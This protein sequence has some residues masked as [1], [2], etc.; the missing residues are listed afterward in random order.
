MPLDPQARALLDVIAS[1][2][3]P[4]L[5]QLPVDQARQA[6]RVAAALQ[7]P[8]E[9]VA[10]V[11]DR[12]LP[13]PVSPIPVRIY[14]PEASAPL[15]LLV[16]FHGGGHTVGDLDSQDATCRAIANRARLLI[17]SVDYRLAPE[18]P[19]P[20]PL[21]DCYAATAWLAE[22]GRSLGADPRRLAVGGD[23]AGGNLAAAVCL[24]ARDLAGP[25]IAF[26]LLI[27]PAVDALC[28]SASHERNAEGYLLTRELI[29]WF[30]GHHVPNEKDKLNPY[31]SPLRAS[32]LAGLPPALVI[33]AEFDPLVDEG[34]AYA[35]RLR[36]AGVKV[37]CQR[38]D[39]MIHGFFG[40]GGFLD[41]AKTAIKQ[42]ADA[43]E[44]ALHD[45]APRGKGASP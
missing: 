37:D 43:L 2:G 17:V 40:M 44:A 26:Q 35:E 31:A 28:E 4:P 12:T 7:I 15:P 18:H 1:S 6:S 9:P 24:K 22:N 39:G 11:E 16:Y 27:Y 41:Q 21:E 45:A 38:Y 34:E 42:A 13:G 33:T 20:A 14:T 5:D 32:S 3:A 30:R 25:P 29:R 23:S 8:L 10:R 19:F 36:A